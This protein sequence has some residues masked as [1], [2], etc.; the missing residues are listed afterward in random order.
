MSQALDGLT[1]AALAECG[2]VGLVALAHLLVRRRRAEALLALALGLIGAAAL[3]HWLSGALQSGSRPLEFSALGAFV[4]SAWCLVLLRHRYAPY[5]RAVFALARLAL[6]LVVLAEVAAASLTAISPPP[7]PLDV[8]DKAAPS[9]A[10]AAWTLFALEPALRF[11][12]ASRAR[13]GV[14]RNRLRLLSVGSLLLIDVWIAELV[15]ALNGVQQ[16]EIAARCAVL[17]TLPLLLVSLAP[18][19][20]LQAVWRS[21]DEAHRREGLEALLAYAPDR[22]AL[23]RRGLGWAMRLSGADAGAITTTSGRVLAALGPAGDLVEMARGRSVAPSTK[24][25]RK[26]QRAARRHVVMLDMQLR[27][28]RA[29]VCLASGPFSRLLDSDETARLRSYA[30]ALTT[31]LDGF[32]VEEEAAVRA[33][34]HEAVLNAMDEMGEGLLVK[35]HG[36]VIYV[37]D[38]YYQITGL[39]SVEIGRSARNG[40]SN[41]A[42]TAAAHARSEPLAAN[43]RET[44][45]INGEG[46]RVFVE[47]SVCEVP[48]GGGDLSVALVRDISERRTAE[49]AMEGRAPQLDLAHDAVFLRA[50]APPEITFW[51]QGAEKAYGF[52]ASDAVGKD[53]HKL[54]QSVLPRPLHEIEEETLRS[55]DWT[56]EVIQQRN[57]GTTRVMASHWSLRINDDGA[58]DGI[59]EVNRDVTERRR[60]ERVRALRVAVTRALSE[61]NSIDDAMPDVLGALCSELEYQIGEVWLLESGGEALRLRHSWHSPGIDGRILEEGG[62]QL[63]LEAGQ[64][65]AGEAWQQRRPVTVRDLADDDTAPRHGAMAV[66]GL[67]AGVAFPAWV[68]EDPVGAVALYSQQQGVIDSGVLQA[69]SDIGR[70]VGGF[71]DRRRTETVLRENVERLEQLAAT[72]PL[73]GLFNAR[74]F[75]HALST[76]TDQPFSLLAVDVDNL[77]AI[78]AEH[79]HEAGDAILRIVATTLQSMLRGHDVVARVGDDEFAVLLPGAGAPSAS[80]VAERMRVAMHSL[81][82]P[83]GRARISVGWTAAPAGADVALVRRASDEVLYRAK[84]M[85]RDRVEGESFDMGRLPER[86]GAQEADLIATVLSSRHI[87]A[88]FQPIVDLNTSEV[89]GYKAL[90]R[91]AGYGPTAS[92]DGLF[93]AARRLGR[94]RDLDWLCRRAAVRSARF[95]PGAPSLFLNVSAVSF[96]DPVHPVDQLLLLLQW[97][98]WAPERTVVEITEQE[99]VRDLA[100]VRLVVAAYR[101]HGIRFALNAR[102]DGTSIPELLLATSPEF[103]KIDAVSSGWSAEGSPPDALMA[104]LAF[105]KS[106]GSQ[107]I[108]RGVETDEMAA[109]MRAVGVPLGQGF[110]LAEPAPAEEL[111]RA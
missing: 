85:G 90:A 73:T 7:I 71:L 19:G 96:L 6:A 102:E 11:W 55:G 21:G 36:R 110:L 44:E 30:H 81:T 94:I 91:P 23:A 56:G 3:L 64:G 17:A 84:S 100:R 95:L 107:V 60:D 35:Q 22:N 37:N 93:T 103:I 45:V 24:A 68:G 2:A 69:L 97:A 77:G 78:N 25:E 8:A 41:G 47:S 29:S 111:A 99:S 76:I 75:E 109:C 43:R 34:R 5:A 98:G 16:L 70:Q 104:T 39:S 53:P 51:S 82:V 86:F 4:L 1:R 65:L 105:A 80:G 63:P 92:V 33:A 49:R 101:E 50:L 12:I 61:A 106:S 79:G 20:W 59:L 54:L 89:V 31:S 42:A 38:A 58:P 46:R 9:L 87:N 108:A 27:D 13:P 72:D 66:L 74:A 62:Q 88:V 28:D 67:H 40:G 15:G 52:S 48:G 26:R 83:Q 57:D 18:P 14:Q 32:R 10:V